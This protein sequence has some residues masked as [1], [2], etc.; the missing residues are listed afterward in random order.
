MYSVAGRFFRISLFRASYYYYYSLLLLLTI[1]M[2]KKRIAPLFAATS[3][4]LPGTSVHERKE[5]MLI[6]N[7][8]IVNAQVRERE[9]CIVA[10]SET[11][12]KEEAKELLVF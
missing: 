6:G 8:R 5:D 10:L 1:Y 3:Y 9:S 7:V 4:Q 11:N 12:T 2:I